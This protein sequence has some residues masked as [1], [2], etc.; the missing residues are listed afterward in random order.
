MPAPLK[1]VEREILE[2]PTRYY[3]YPPKCL[4]DIDLS[5]IRDYPPIDGGIKPLVQALRGLGLL[6]MGSCE[7][8]LC[9]RRHPHPWVSVYGLWRYE[10]LYPM[11]ETFNET[12]EVKWII[13]GI[14]LCPSTEASNEIKLK[15]LQISA[16]NLAQYLFDNHISNT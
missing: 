14:I 2:K 8:H 1:M 4:E 9:G 13:D 11:I 10:E 16:Q 3:W 6:T 7:G 15:K 12:S 5:D